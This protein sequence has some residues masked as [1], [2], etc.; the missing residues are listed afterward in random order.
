MKSVLIIEPHS[1]LAQTYAK[2]FELAGLVA[3]VASSAQEAVDVADGQLPDVVVLELQ[4]SNHSGL[5]FLHEFRS[6]SD[7]RNIPVIINTNI[8][9]SRL[10]SNPEALKQ[11]GVRQVLYKPRT[12]L[13]ELIREVRKLI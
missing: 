8:P 9:I 10:N 5:E 3:L 11:L 6:Y 13:K 7:W 12:T 2:S 1:V 4:M